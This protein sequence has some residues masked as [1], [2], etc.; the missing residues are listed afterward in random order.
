MIDW[1]RY[2]L[3]DIPFL[4]IPAIKIDS[5]DIRANGRLYYKDVAREQLET[6]KKMI[7]SD[8]F[9]AV[10]LRT[11]E[12]VLGNGK[13]AF[14]A[15]AYWDLHDQDKNLLW[16]TA[17][18]N[19]RMRDLLS[20]ILDSMVMQ[21][22]LS[23]LRQSLKPISRRTIEEALEKRGQKLGPSTLYAILQLLLAEEHKLTYV[24]SNIRR[25]IPVQLH[26]DLFG[27]FLNLFYA[28]GES[29]FTVFIDQFEEYVRSHETMG[30]RLRLAHDIN[31]LQRSIGESTTLVVSLHPRAEAILTTSAPESETFTRI[32][33]SS[34]ELPPFD[35]NS[36]VKM[37]EFYFNAFRPNN[38]GGAPLHPFEEKVIRYSAHR[39][40]MNARDLILALRAGLIHCS[41]GECNKINGEFLSKYHQKMF[42]GLENEWQNF[43]A[44]K[45]TYER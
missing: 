11:R 42:G 44:G 35:E 17:T 45:F 2:S 31:D 32:E 4:A 12:T 7:L 1:S 26:T 30:E 3:R 19:P 15:A 14:L 22:K 9:P 40:S 16:C 8:Y 43:L 13:S 41:F 38:Y 21:G 37:V 20:R 29:R 23:K 24:Y 27:A 10:F 18:F 6:I 33:T 25:R 5:P 36:L 28:I 39:T 34:V